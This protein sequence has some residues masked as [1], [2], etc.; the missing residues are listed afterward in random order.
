M[1]KY[2]R[3]IVEDIEARHKFEKEQQSLKKKYQ[4][5]TEKIVVEKNNTFKFMIRMVA[6]MVRIAAQI[7]IC[8]LAIL[9][10]MCLIYP[11]PRA[12]LIQVLF[13]IYQSVLA[14]TPI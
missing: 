3:G 14:Y 12:A 4:L 13:E 8:A 7:I 10:L 9:G 6:G 1:S 5:D 2:K 11:G